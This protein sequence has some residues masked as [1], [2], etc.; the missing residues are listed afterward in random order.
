MTYE[1]D[2]NRLAEE[3]K[4]SSE[5]AGRLVRY[6]AFAEVC[7][8]LTEKGIPQENLRIAVA[9]NADDQAETILFRILRGAGTDGLSGIRYSRRDQYGN[10][11]IRP[12]LDI[13]REE[14]EAYCEEKHLEPCIDK[15]NLAPVYTRNKIRLELLPYLEKTFNP[16]IKETLIR[17]GK[18]A[19]EDSRFIR[20]EA[21][22]AYNR[23]VIEV[24]S[25]LVLFSGPVLRNIDSA[26]RKRVLGEGLEAIGITEDIGAVHFECCEDIIFNKRPSARNDLPGGAYITKVYDNVKLA[27]K[28][29]GGTAEIRIS[30]VSRKTYDSMEKVRDRFCAFDYSLMEEELGADFMDRVY[31]RTREPGDYIIIGEGHQKKLQNYFVDNKVPKDERDSISVVAVGHEILWILPGKQKGRYNSRY[32][33]CPDT[34]K[35]FLI[36]ILSRL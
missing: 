17:M 2:C 15:T 11:I 3:K 21:H 26:V 22:K 8:T 28:G 19:A 13:T 10:R 35:V 20:E 4:I 14:I 23:A 27:R 34:K 29:T 16:G 24:N 33:L 32:K 1:V 31:C 30:T 7:R 5:E 12:L 9:Q 36:E 25:E 18:N 6:G